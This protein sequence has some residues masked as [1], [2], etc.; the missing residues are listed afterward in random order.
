[1]PTDLTEEEIDDHTETAI[2]ILVGLG[3][4]TETFDKSH[5]FRNMGKLMNDPIAISIGA[6]FMK[7]S[8]M[9]QDKS[10]HLKLID[11]SDFD[12]F[13]REQDE[14]QVGC[15]SLNLSTLLST[16]GC[17]PNVSY[18]YTRDFLCTWHSLQPIKKGDRLI[19]FDA[20][21]TI[22][23]YQPKP[24]RLLELHKSYNSSC[25]C[26]ACAENWSAE[27]LRKGLVESVVHPDH[28]MT[29]G[30]IGELNYFLAERQ[31]KSATYMNPDMK[32]MDRVKDLL[33]RAWQRFA[34]PSTIITRAM[35]IYWE[36]LRYFYWQ[37]R[38]DFK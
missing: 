33:L 18:I 37:S 12:R 15:S 21:A 27:D 14:N 2:G 8:I 24:R 13:S 25:D 16:N 36:S 34:L 9:T 26:R 11:P 4:L 30:M 32:T 7:L 1:M 28:Y 29:V 19:H 17:I 5:D 31:S 6:L 23:N 3:M 10:L 20:D 35:R 22:F 38:Y